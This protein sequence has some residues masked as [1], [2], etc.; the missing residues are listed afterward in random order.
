MMKV[1]SILSICLFIQA[2]SFAQ[3]NTEWRQDDMDLIESVVRLDK[4]QPQEV[5]IFFQDR[6]HLAR[7]PDTL[8]FGWTKMEKGIGAGYISI[9]ADFFYFKD[10]IKAYILNTYLPHEDA[11]KDEYRAAYLKCFSTNNDL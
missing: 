3:I 8:G 10:T 6:H 9:H 5:E 1:W 7:K 2:Y 11:L 4:N